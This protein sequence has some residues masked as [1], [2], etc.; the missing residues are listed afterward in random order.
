MVQSPAKWN[1]NRTADRPAYSV[2]GTST[3]A[4]P[5]TSAGCGG[6]VQ[7]LFQ[8][9]PPSVVMSTEAFCPNEPR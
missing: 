6:V 5:G 3:V 2:S 7:T 8:V 9:L 4:G 1:R